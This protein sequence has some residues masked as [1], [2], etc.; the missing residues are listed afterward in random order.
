MLSNIFRKNIHFRVVNFVIFIITILKF[1]T[2]FVQICK[3]IP[4]FTIHICKFFSIFFKNFFRLF[5]N[6]CSFFKTKFIE[7]L[8]KNLIKN[9]IFIAIVNHLHKSAICHL[10][11]Q[12]AINIQT[13]LLIG[14]IFKN[15]FLSFF[16]HNR[17]IYI[18]NFVKK[19]PRIFMIFEFFLRNFWGKFF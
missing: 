16:V 14:N 13:R 7:F 12:I 15:K 8:Y 1:W 3:C 18:E 17:K 6:F 4:V 11:V 19:I 10:R 5:Y 9:S 2:F